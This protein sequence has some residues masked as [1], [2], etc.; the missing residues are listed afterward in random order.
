MFPA[1][2]PQPQQDA[3]ITNTNHLRGTLVPTEPRSQPPSVVAD[4]RSHADVRGGGL[5]ASNAPP[6]VKAAACL[7]G[8]QELSGGVKPTT[9]HIHLHR[10]LSQAG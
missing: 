4:L 10:G 1:L 5:M 2:L 7:N 9:H 8:A 3:Q 6:C